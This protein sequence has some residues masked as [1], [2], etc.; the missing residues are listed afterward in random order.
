MMIICATG[1]VH[2]ATVDHHEWETTVRTET[3]QWVHQEGWNAPTGSRTIRN[4]VKSR[5]ASG[6]RAVSSGGYITSTTTKHK[7]ATQTYHVWGYR[8]CPYCGTKHRADKSCSCGNKELEGGYTPSDEKVAKSQEKTKEGHFCSY[9][10]NFST[11]NKCSGCGHSFDVSDK[12]Y[13]S[14][15]DNSCKKGNRTYQ[16]LGN[17]QFLVTETTS[18]E[19]ES[20]D[21]DYIPPVYETEYSDYYEWEELLW[22]TNRTFPASGVGTSV[23]FKEIQLQEGER[24]GHSSAKYTIVYKV[25]DGTSITRTYKEDEWRRLHDG[26][27]VKARKW[28][29]FCFWYWVSQ[30]IEMP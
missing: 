25:D 4:L 13:S 6:T 26:N 28:W 30:E 9:C 3:Q 7:D 21:V 1:C 19:Y 2:T 15:F 24:A 10:G 17:G 8:T 22:R 11:G 14:K 18:R 12:R 29:T 5:R 16:D 23:E 27:K 20:T